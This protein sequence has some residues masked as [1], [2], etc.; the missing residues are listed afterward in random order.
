[1][2]STENMWASTKKLGPTLIPLDLLRVFG[3]STPGNTILDLPRSSMLWTS[4]A[5]V[6]EI[7]A[8]KAEHLV[9]AVDAFGK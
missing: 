1:M 4:N 2:S 6:S 5:T 8:D 9:A 7:Y 3:L